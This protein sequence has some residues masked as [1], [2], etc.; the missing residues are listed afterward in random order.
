MAKAGALCGPINR[1]LES[2]S[3]QRLLTGLATLL[4]HQSIVHA[5]AFYRVQPG[6]DKIVLYGKQER[7]R[8]VVTHQVRQLSKGTWTSKLDKLALIR[9]RTPEALS[10][11]SYGQPIAV[12]VRVRR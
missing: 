6:V 11:P 5:V 2:A 4:Q 10:G 1:H 12:Y 3:P 7:G 8:W 9:H